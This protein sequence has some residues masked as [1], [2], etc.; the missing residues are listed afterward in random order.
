MD[1][2]GVYDP[3]CDQQAFGA[4]VHDGTVWTLPTLQAVIGVVFD[5]LQDVG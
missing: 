5:P 3:V 2:L 1:R 4:I